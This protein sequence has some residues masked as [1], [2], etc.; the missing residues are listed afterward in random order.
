MPHSK[1]IW[2]KTEDVSQVCEDFTYQSTSGQIT[3][4]RQRAGMGKAAG[5]RVA[6]GGWQ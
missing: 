3:N 2:T 4:D 1:Y 5:N 6:G